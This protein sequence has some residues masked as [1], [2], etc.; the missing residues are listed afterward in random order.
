MKF[1]G[2]LNRPQQPN[3]YITYEDD[4]L[5]SEGDVQNSP[6][7]QD[8]VVIL[9][10]TA[11]AASTEIHD[12]FIPLT[13]NDKSSTIYTTVVSQSKPPPPAYYTAIEPIVKPI[14]KQETSNL[15]AEL[16]QSVID[17]S[18]SS[19][20]ASNKTVSRLSS[21]PPLTKSAYPLPIPV[22]NSNKTDAPG[23]DKNRKKN[24]L[25]P[26]AKTRTIK[27]HEYKGP[28]NAQKNGSTTM[29]NEET[30]YQLLLKQQNCLL[31][32]LEG[33]HKSPSSNSQS[34]TKSML[35]ENQSSFSVTNS[36]KQQSS[37]LASNATSIKPA[38]PV[39][40]TADINNL[41]MSKLEKMKVSDLKLLLKTRNLPVS[42]PKP[43]LIE[44]LRPFIQTEANVET[45]TTSTNSS[46][47]I[48]DDDNENL[49]NNSPLHMETDTMELHETLNSR[50][51]EAL[52]REQQRKIDEL[53]RKLK[54]SQQELQ[55]M[56]MKQGQASVV[57]MITNEIVQPKPEVLNQKQIFKQQLE[58]KIQKDK[59]Q[60][61]QLEQQE[62]QQ[63]K[64]GNVTIL[65][66]ILKKKLNNIEID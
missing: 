23:K 17:N 53:Q 65:R 36:F 16:C 66:I 27:F 42:G 14:V 18:G 2:L 59:L 11:T 58:A 37:P 5:S 29:T 56:Q 8:S 15:F 44:R 50:T 22:Q 48:T 54:E 26:M 52:L 57:K 49:S 62:M 38:S 24:K 33:L 20:L 43:Q 19:N 39:S 61:I 28:P 1:A 45:M 3:G 47:N 21:L 30:S 10:P 7:G 63:R 25:K 46:E 55:Q 4:S 12:F 51:N 41:E 13:T 40:I 31:E 6:A 9:S 60:K 35:N 32:Y 64:Q 34:N